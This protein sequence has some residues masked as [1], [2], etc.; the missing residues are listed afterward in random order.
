MDPG[1]W[2]EHTNAIYKL[3]L[4]LRNPICT[5]LGKWHVERKMNIYIIAFF[6]TIAVYVTF[7][8]D[9]IHISQ[10]ADVTVI[11]APLLYPLFVIP[12]SLM[13]V[14]VGHLQTYSLMLR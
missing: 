11:L 2:L 4:L 12:L 10:P 13:R 5:N 6:C 1:K 14:C 7:L 3:L 9:N 8:K